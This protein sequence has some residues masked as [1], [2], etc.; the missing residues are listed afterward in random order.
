MLQTSPLFAAVFPYFMRY[1]L[2]TANAWVL[3]I[4]NS[5]PAATKAEMGLG[6]AGAP[7]LCVHSP[8]V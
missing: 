2:P 7:F 1:K 3:N 6:A 8:E 5:E 4:L